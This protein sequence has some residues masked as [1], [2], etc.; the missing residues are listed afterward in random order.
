MQLSE[1]YKVFQWD[2]ET[3][4]NIMQQSKIYHGG[5]MG[6]GS[7]FSAGSVPPTSFNKERIWINAEQFSSLS[8]YPPNGPTTRALP[9]TLNLRVYAF[10]PTEL[11]LAFCWIPL[12]TSFWTY[13]LTAPTS[14]TLRFFWY[15]DNTS[16][17]VVAWR[18]EL[19]YIR[20]METLNFAMPALTVMNEAAGNKY[21]LHMQEYADFPIYN[22]SGSAAETEGAFYFKIGRDGPSAQ[23]TFGFEAYLIA[24]SIEFPLE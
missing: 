3:G 1:M 18:G 19:I 9:N 10:S 21:Q 17:D 12:P 16:A 15:T 4:R 24:A 5:S 22:P 8:A 20:D 14:C 7:G 6:R 13:K 23:D 11:D 2:K